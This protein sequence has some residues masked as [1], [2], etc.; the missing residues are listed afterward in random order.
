MG[1]LTSA[2]IFASMKLFAIYEKREKGERRE[3]RDRR[4]KKDNEREREREMIKSST[5]AEHVKPP[6][7]AVIC[8][9][10]LLKMSCAASLMCLTVCLSPLLSPLPSPLPLLPSVQQRASFS[11]SRAIFS[12]ISIVPAK[13]EGR[14]ERSRR[15]GRGETHSK[16]ARLTTDVQIELCAVCC[17]L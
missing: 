13:K 6:V 1:F 17:V 14:G 7:F 5:P 4:K 9:R 11:Q 16:Q 2:A 12:S 3:E 15:E 8:R 10:T